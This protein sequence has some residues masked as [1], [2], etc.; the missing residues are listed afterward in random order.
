MSGNK[1]GGCIADKGNEGCEER[2]GSAVESEEWSFVR[3]RLLY[4]RLEMFPGVVL[5]IWM[6]VLHDRYLIFMICGIYKEMM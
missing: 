1:I 3:G 6:D 5:G 2:E 4:V